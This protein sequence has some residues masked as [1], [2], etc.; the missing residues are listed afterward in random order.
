VRT[1]AL[2]DLGDVRSPRVRRKTG[3]DD[4]AGEVLVGQQYPVSFLFQPGRSEG[5]SSRLR[6][7]ERAGNRGVGCGCGL[8]ID[9]PDSGVPAPETG[10]D[11]FAGEVLVGQQYPVSFLFQPG[12]SEGLSS[13]LRQPKCGRRLR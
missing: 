11:D 8:V 1:N 2:I 7:P 10:G 5:L 13:R 4:F 12:R 3:G 9:S 6:Q